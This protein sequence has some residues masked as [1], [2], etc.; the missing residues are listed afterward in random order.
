MQSCHFHV[1]GSNE[2]VSLKMTGVVYQVVRYN[3]PLKQLLFITI[4]KHTKQLFNNYI[5]F[6]HQ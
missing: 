5:I 2:E 6:F 1:S 3:T 4:N